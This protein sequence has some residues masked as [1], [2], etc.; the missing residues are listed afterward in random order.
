MYFLVPL[1]AIVIGGCKNSN[2]K[3]VK[4]KISQVTLSVGSVSW[5]FGCVPMND[6]E[7]YAT[8]VWVS[9]VEQNMLI[10]GRGSG[11]SIFVRR[12]NFIVLPT[13][14]E[15]KVHLLCKL[16]GSDVSLDIMVR[17]RE[18]MSNTVALENITTKI[19]EAILKALYADYGMTVQ[20]TGSAK[21]PKPIERGLK[22]KVITTGIVEAQ[23][24]PVV[25]SNVIVPVHN[26]ATTPVPVHNSPPAPAIPVASNSVSVPTSNIPP[27]A[28]NTNVVASSTASPMAENSSFSGSLTSSPVTVISNPEAVLAST[29]SQS[30]NSQAIVV[31]NTD[32]VMYV[33][34]TSSTGL[35]PAQDVAAPAQP[36]QN[37]ANKSE[38]KIEG[39]TENL[40]KT[41]EEPKSLGTDLLSA[42]TP[43]PGDN[44]SALTTIAKTEDLVKSDSQADSNPHGL[45]KEAS[46][47]GYKRILE[48][49]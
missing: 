8:R 30:D 4:D 35:E 29:N 23:S 26:I 13:C 45:E 47:P 9:K 39:P 6:T 43:V 36:P 44:N 28:S 40:V 46:G 16:D 21:V 42:S 15:F 17:G 24:S 3:E 2:I 33:S 34:Q 10:S 12:S 32:Q 22:S 20:E 38:V 14:T 25:P 41:N 18:K 7:G 37:E 1:L 11:L 49:V 31:N 5:D 27:A 48:Q 19:A